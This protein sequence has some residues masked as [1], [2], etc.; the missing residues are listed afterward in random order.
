[1]LRVDPQRIL[2]KVDYT[3]SCWIWSWSLDRHG[4][5][6]VRA[7]GTTKR[8]HRI[9]YELLVGEVAEGLDLDHICRNRSCVNPQHLEPVTR[10]QNLLRGELWQSKKTCCPEGHPYDLIDNRGARRCRKCL[11]RI[12]HRNY[13]K[14]KATSA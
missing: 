13:L 5:G 4:Y 14:R 1:M 9:V 6:Q 3:D 10:S 12:A 11:K 2:S 8:A 7:F